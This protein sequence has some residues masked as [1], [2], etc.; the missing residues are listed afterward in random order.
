MKRR[1][2]ASM[3]AKA[4]KSYDLFPINLNAGEADVE[5]QSDPEWGWLVDYILTEYDHLYDEV[6]IDT[7]PGLGKLT[8]NGI[9]AA[10]D[11]VI[12][13]VADEWATQGMIRLAASITRAQRMK[14]ELQVAGILFTRYRYKN[15]REV[16]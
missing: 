8:M 3:P 16:M 12:P 6:F 4:I 1:G 9:V 13:L 5:L 2:L 15:H 14:P 11:I 10:T 7:N